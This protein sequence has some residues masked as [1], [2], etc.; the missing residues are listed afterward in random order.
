MTAAATIDS[1]ER[2][3]AALAGEIAD[4][5]PLTLWRHWPV[6]DQ[7]AVTHAR[8]AVAHHRRLG[9]DILKLTPSAAFMSEAW[10]AV[11]EY[12]GAATGV[13]DYVT[14]PVS[15][16]A[17]WG[18]VTRL[19][20]NSVPSMARE[21]EVVRRVRADVG[22]QTPVLAT[23]FT[24]LSVVRY[25][26]GDGVFTSHLRRDPETVARAMRAIAETTIDL[27]RLLL[28]AGAD[29]IY[30]SLF[31]ASYAVM[32]EVEYRELVLP[33]DREV[34][35][36]AEDAW[37]RVAHFHL[38]DPMLALASALPV[39]MVSWEHTHGGPDL[40]EGARIAGHAV[41]GGV[42]QVGP[43]AWAD[44]DT[45]RAEGRELVRA[46]RSMLPAGLIAATSCSYPLTTPEGNLLALRDG[47]VAGPL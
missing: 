40:A 18:V 27:V 4:R 6:D 9:L 16:P 45:V 28:D 32:S 12:R 25:L 2:V 22:P 5:P 38:P 43:L 46:A 15:E 29:G 23:V 13:R 34:M 47:L 35:E 21:V 37:L 17:D 20:P 1:R 3:A 41:I 36:A 26:A 11:T 14:R 10:G 39:N 19:A 42:D 31:S 7:D 30:F 44:A 33:S 8:V 24:P